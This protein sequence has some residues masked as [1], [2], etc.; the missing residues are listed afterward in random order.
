MTD[1]LD[2]AG[3]QASLDSEA[4]ADLA[5][6]VG[7]RGECQHLPQRVAAAEQASAEQRL[8]KSRGVLDGRDERGA[9]GGAGHRGVNAGEVDLP[10]VDLTVARGRD[11]RS[12]TDRQRQATRFV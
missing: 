6:H 12:Q 9:A 4:V 1:R 10:S 11:G 7:G 8:E 2:A 5:A 3:K